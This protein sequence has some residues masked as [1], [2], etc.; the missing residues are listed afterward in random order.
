MKTVLGGG[1]QTP[2]A[3]P[4][5]FRTWPGSGTWAERD[6]R[7]VR[8]FVFWA[9][10]ARAILGSWHKQSLN[11]NNIREKHLFP[12]WHHFQFGFLFYPHGTF[13]MV[14]PRSVWPIVVRLLCRCFSTSDI[15]VKY[16]CSSVR[17]LRGGSFPTQRH[18]Y[19]PCPCRFIIE[20]NN[21]FLVVT[22]C[23]RVNQTIAI[24]RGM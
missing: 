11:K 17:C 19:I 1:A 2:L 9:V 5:P 20:R 12:R 6:K 18:H 4:Y 23:E 7:E 22:D 15:T 3:L 8:N 21:L 24:D 13:F 14:T 10:Y 16:L